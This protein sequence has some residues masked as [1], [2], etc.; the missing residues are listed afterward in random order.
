MLRPGTRCGSSQRSPRPP[1]R[2]GRG[3]PPPQTPPLGAFGA[4]ILAPAALVFQPEP[5]HFLKRSGALDHTAYCH[6]S[7]IDKL[8]LQA[9]CH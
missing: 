9:K 1:S 2:L 6:A 4:S 8:Y 3:T 5:Y 7:P